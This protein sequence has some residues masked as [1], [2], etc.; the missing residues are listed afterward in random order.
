MGRSGERGDIRDNPD[1]HRNGERPALVRHRCGDGRADSLGCS[2][3]PVHHQAPLAAEDPREDAA[4][5]SGRLAG[6]VRSSSRS[7]SP[8]TRATARCRR[9]A[10]R[11]PC[12]PRR[13]KRSSRSRCFSRRQSSLPMTAWRP[14]RA[15]QRT[16]AAVTPRTAAEVRRPMAVAYS[17]A[18]RPPSTVQSSPGGARWRSPCRRDPTTL[19]SSVVMRLTVQVP[20]YSARS[21]R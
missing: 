10:G 18:N 21:R 13:S 20:T 15:S 7:T 17:L 1:Q 4:C 8:P 6:P 16:R 5:T 12:R 11:T 2:R 3:R 19:T 9:A 14:T